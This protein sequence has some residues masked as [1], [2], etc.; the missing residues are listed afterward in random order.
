[1]STRW[2]EPDIKIVDPTNLFLLNVQSREIHGDVPQWV[3]WTAWC[4][5]SSRLR[6]KKILK[7]D[8]TTWTP[9]VPDCNTPWVYVGGNSNDFI[10][11]IMCCDW[12]GDRL[13]EL[14]L[15]IRRQQT[16]K[17]ISLCFTLDTRKNCV[18][19]AW[20]PTCG[21]PGGQQRIWEKKT[22]WMEARSLGK[23]GTIE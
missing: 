9:S 10:L 13:E 22:Y 1:M 11:W 21:L 3:G 12:G 14:L 6:D 23:K 5:Q 7:A 16:S 15:D 4:L 8:S 19:R 2:Q 20:S 18:L 17:P